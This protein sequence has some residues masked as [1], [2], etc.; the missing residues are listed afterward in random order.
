MEYWQILL[1]IIVGTFAGWINVMAG[2]GSL[3]TIPVMLF[4][5]IPAPVANGTNRS[6]ER[7]VA[8]SAIAA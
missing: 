1:L 3:L 5:D 6:L 8:V 2:G 7:F 4:M